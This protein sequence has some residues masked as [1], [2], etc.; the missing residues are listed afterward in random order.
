MVP[1]HKP[2]HTIFTMLTVASLLK[3]SS[4]GFSWTNTRVSASQTARRFMNARTGSYAST[5]SSGALPSTASAR[6]LFLR[7]QDSSSLQ[8]TEQTDYLCSQVLSEGQGRKMYR[9]KICPALP[10]GRAGQGCTRILPEEF[11]VHRRLLWAGAAACQRRSSP[12][13]ECRC[14]RSRHPAG[15]PSVCHPL[16]CRATGSP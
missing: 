11:R 12:R 3:F 5:R 16:S 2:T 6:W 9:R 13:W 7:I 1:K 15:G 8:R 14:S 10:K 4:R